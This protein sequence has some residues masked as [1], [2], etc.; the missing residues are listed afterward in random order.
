MYGIS[1]LLSASPAVEKCGQCVQK[2]REVHIEVCS[3]LPRDVGGIYIIPFS[4]FKSF[5][6]SHDDVGGHFFLCL[7]DSEGEEWKLWIQRPEFLWDSITKPGSPVLTWVIYA[8]VTYCMVGAIKM[9]TTNRLVIGGC[10]KGLR[11]KNPGSV[12]YHISF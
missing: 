6:S 10:G 9:K 12:K 2:C 1:S 5:S 8:S 7:L 4:R 3:Y 11:E